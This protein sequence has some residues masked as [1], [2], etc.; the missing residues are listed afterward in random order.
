[1]GRRSLWALRRNRPETRDRRWTVS[2]DGTVLRLRDSKG[3]GSLA[4]LLGR[5]GKPIPAALLL[6]PDGPSDGTVANAEQS[7][8]AATKRLEAAVKKIQEYHPSLG[9]HLTTC[10]KTGHFCSYTP[11]LGRSLW[12]PSDRWQLTLGI[13]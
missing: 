6:D 5:P 7:R 11:N 8:V 9:H 4:D 2:Y 13:P 12:A 1:L 10:I 3:M